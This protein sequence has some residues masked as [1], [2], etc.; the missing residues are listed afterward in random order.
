MDSPSEPELT[1]PPNLLMDPIGNRLRGLDLTA[2]PTT[3]D[4]KES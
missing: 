3:T 2:A 1:R 4:D